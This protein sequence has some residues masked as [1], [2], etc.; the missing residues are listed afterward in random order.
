MISKLSPMMSALGHWEKF[1]DPNMCFE[2]SQKPNCLLSTC[3][4]LH[5]KGSGGKSKNLKGNYIPA[6]L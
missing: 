5:K 4:T 3:V 1:G 6:L 2:K